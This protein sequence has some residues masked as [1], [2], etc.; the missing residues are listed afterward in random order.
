MSE[1][2][3]WSKAPE[4]AM[5]LLKHVRDNRYAWAVSHAEE[6]DAWIVDDTGYSFRLMASCWRVVSNRPTTPSWSGEGLPP[7]G[8]VCEISAST[9]YLKIS[10]P[11]GT[12]VKVYA[13]FTDDRGVE[14][15]AFVDELGMVAGVAIAKCF[16]PIRT[17]EQV[18]ADEREAAIAEI[19][20]LIA[21]YSY[22]HCAEQIYKAGY[23]KQ[24]KTERDTKKQKASAMCARQSA[25]PASQTR[26]TGRTTR[27]L[28]TLG[29]LIR[30]SRQATGKSTT[31]A[32][33]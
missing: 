14:L 6:S 5:V 12:R 21:G 1:Q 29:F 18:A 16:R 8:T 27:S 13:T 22:R 25:E 4:G 28:L 33:R 3:D 31:R 19:E 30:I 10:H 11:E 24:E 7:V 17:P 2:I 26:N 20:E 32:S 9:E 23:R 15:A